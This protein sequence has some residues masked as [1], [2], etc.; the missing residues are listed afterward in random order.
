LNQRQ[1]VVST[2]A[3]S[4]VPETLNQDQQPGLFEECCP[5]TQR[6]RDV[7]Q[8][9]EHVP[10]QDDVEALGNVRPCRVADRE[11]DVDTAAGSLLYGSVEHP[12]GD[13][14]P[15]HPIAELGQQHGQ[16]SSAAPKG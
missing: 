9:P 12:W 3:G 8:R 1:Q 4:G 11:T 15:R 16:C 10:T 13:V 5:A 7:R 2:Q 14:Q 6:R